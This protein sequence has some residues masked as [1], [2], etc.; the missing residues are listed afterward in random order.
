MDDDAEPK[1]N[2]LEKLLECKVE[3]AV[4]I[5]PME[6]ENGKLFHYH[7]GFFSSSIFSRGI[8]KR[9]KEAD[10]KGRCIEIDHSSFVGLLIKSDAVREIGLPQEDFFI[11]F[12]DLEYCLRLK[13]CGKI[14]MSTNSLI[15]HKAELKKKK[16]TW[17]FL[18]DHYYARRNLLIVLKQY[19]KAKFY[20]Y[21]LY[22]LLRSFLELPFILISGEDVG[23]KLRA[24][25]KA[26]FHGITGKVGRTF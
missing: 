8:L 19:S 25:L 4:A 21:S 5:T 26:I 17:P 23:V 1:K 6:E 20:M 12:D 3:D 16:G 22:F 24:N 7:R 2:S 13:K 18:V 15:I 11:K 10:I 9:L 14:Y